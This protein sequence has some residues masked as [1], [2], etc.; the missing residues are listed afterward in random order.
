[1]PTS[2]SPGT[3][4]L[5]SGER[6]QTTVG[7]R[8]EDLQDM[9]LWVKLTKS[10]PVDDSLRGLP[11]PAMVKHVFGTAEDLFVTSSSTFD[12]GARSLQQGTCVGALWQ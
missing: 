8:R 3:S 9:P 1:M 12:H 11:W 4:G 10:R 2:P 6:D 7:S 5:P